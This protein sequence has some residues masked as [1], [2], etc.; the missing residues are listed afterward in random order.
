MRTTVICVKRAYKMYDDGGPPESLF[1]RWTENGLLKFV[2]FAVIRDCSGV[3]LTSQKTI[4]SFF[5]ENIALP[6]KKNNTYIKIT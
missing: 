3:L 6:G 5:S 1:F 2:R 4:T